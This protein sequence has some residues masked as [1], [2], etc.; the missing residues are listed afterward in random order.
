[1]LTSSFLTCSCSSHFNFIV[2]LDQLSKYVKVRAQPLLF[3]LFPCIGIIV[4]VA[5]IGTN[6][7]HANVSGSFMVLLRQKCHM[8]NTAY[9]IGLIA[10]ML[11]FKTLSEVQKV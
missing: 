5:E 2:Y 8:E 6:Q 7:K 3:L 4:G 11:K 9:N 1:M 10:I